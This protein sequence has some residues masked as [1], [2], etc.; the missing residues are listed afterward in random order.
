MWPFILA[1]IA[2]I[3][4]AI[5]LT[6]LFLMPL[7]NVGTNIIILYFLFLRVYTEVTKHKRGEVYLLSGAAAALGLVLIG[8]FLPVW[9]ITTA[10]LL[11]FV[12][13][14]AYLAWEKS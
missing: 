7:I 11:A 4:F 12:I 10:S 9:W 5:I 13:A 2:F 3:I 14:H 6:T 8:N 1:L